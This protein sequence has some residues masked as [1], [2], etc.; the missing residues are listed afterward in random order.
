MGRSNHDALAE[1]EILILDPRLSQTK[2]RK[3]DAK[4]K[5]V[6]HSSDRIKSGIEIATQG[7][8]RLCR[9]CNKRVTHDKRNCP[10]NPMSKQNKQ[11][12]I[13]EDSDEEDGN[14]EI[15]DANSED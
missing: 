14:L 7:R 3:K 8:K 2:G 4:G 10:L 11:S 6:T 5:V 15:E 9:S 1:K 13:N 12:Q